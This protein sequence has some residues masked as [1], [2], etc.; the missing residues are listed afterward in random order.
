MSNTKEISM[1]GIKIRLKPRVKYSWTRSMK[2][3]I[4]GVVVGTSLIKD[5]EDWDNSFMDHWQFFVVWDQ[6]IDNGEQFCS[7][8]DSD[9]C[10]VIGIDVRYENA[11]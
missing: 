1:I 7:Y 3:P 8:I 9:E 10:D 4:T 2:E 5:P 6:T 11:K